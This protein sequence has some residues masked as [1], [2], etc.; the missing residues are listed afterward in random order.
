MTA[1]IPKVNLTVLGA[2]GSGKT[3]FM[4]GMY[5]AMSAGV[6]NYF[7]YTKDP[8]DDIDLM[9][10]WSALC[11][12]GELPPATSV[13]G[14]KRYDFV[15]KHGFDSLLTIDCVDF[16]G[17]VLDVKTTSADDAKEIHERLLVTDT[18]YMVLDGRHLGNWIAAIKDLPEGESL[19][20]NPGSDP[21]RIAKMSRLLDDAVTARRARG[22]LAPSVVVLIT[23]IDLI[24][25]LSGLEWK[26][27]RSI[28]VRQLQHIMPKI[29][30]PGITALIC[31]VQVGRFGL[32]QY[33]KV[34]PSEVDP[35]GV[36]LP[37][38]FSLLYYLTE[39]LQQQN[40]EMAAYRASQSE[41]AA[42]LRELEGKFTAQLFQRGDMRRM[43][44]EIDQLDGRMSELGGRMSTDESTIAKLVEQLAKY[45]IIKDGRFQI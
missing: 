40:A 26:K 19:T 8:D 17:G 37:F 41:S 10:A 20:L 38:I 31:P 21:M 28:A 42:K 12:T 14:Q 6:A 36:H 1:N 27:A 25:A 29:F 39:T 44:E 11:E 35:V 13:D 43:R 22:Q 7:L 2:S 4:H 45:P 23:K 18:V 3:L 32:E 30:Q 34:D 15:L 16:R 24:P 5:A 33:T 9:D